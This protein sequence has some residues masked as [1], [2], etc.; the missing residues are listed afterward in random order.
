[1]IRWSV[2]YP[3]L[4]HT[5]IGDTTPASMVDVVQP[6]VSWLNRALWLV[7]NMAVIQVAG[8]THNMHVLEL[9]P[10]A[11]EDQR[12]GLVELPDAERANLDRPASADASCAAFWSSDSAGQQDGQ[13]P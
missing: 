5:T 13:S 4:N 2:S 8:C 11:E 3:V 1:M 9:D 6:V 10:F 7:A 12:T